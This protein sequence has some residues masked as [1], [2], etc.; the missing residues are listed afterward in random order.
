RT[1]HIK[2]EFISLVSHELRT[3][4]TVITG[5]LSVAMDR[6]ISSDDSKQLLQEAVHSSADLAQILDNMLELSRYQSNR[7]QLTVTRTNI[8]QL[9]QNIAETEKKRLDSHSLSL[10]IADGLPPIDV[11]EIR[12]CQIMR[13]LISNSVK[14][15]PSNTEIHVSVGKNDEHILV[16]IRDEGNGISPEDQARLF[17]PFERLQQNSSNKPGLGL[18]L[19]VCRRLVE[20]HGGKIWVDSKP[21]KGSTFWFTLPLPPTHN[22]KKKEAGR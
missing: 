16:G 10:E 2:D 15:S 12:V 5:A 19:L 20:A 6:G 4:M 14:Y 11:D 7:L 8:V 18:G 22:S 3:P 21:G 9:L 13:N 17:Q 1:E